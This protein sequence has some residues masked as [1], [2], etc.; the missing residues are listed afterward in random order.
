[1]NNDDEFITYGLRIS[2]FRERYANE[3]G[4]NIDIPFAKFK[5]GSKVRYKGSNESLK[6]YLGKEFIVSTVSSCD[7]TCEYSLRGLPYLVWE[8]EIESI[9]GE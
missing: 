5:M 3:F 2:E 9:Q 6:E 4:L 8:D 7:N 1:M